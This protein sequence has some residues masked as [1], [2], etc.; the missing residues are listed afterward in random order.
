MPAAWDTSLL[1]ELR[2]GSGA[3][4]FALE[5]AGRGQPVA[6]ASTAVLES[7]YGYERVSSA[8]PDFGELLRWL[9]QQVNDPGFLHVLP[10]NAR[11][12]FAVG[13]LRAHEPAPPRASKHD[14]RAKTERRAAWVLDLQIAATC[15][16][17]GHDVATRN[18]QDFE[19]IAELLG[20]LAPGA[21]PL[22]V[23]D[24]PF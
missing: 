12:A 10:L 8:R 19:S 4:L 11:A 20:E 1:S 6:V 15:W 3:H 2:P 14:R 5:Q 18:G 16:S 7:A 22:E 13:R 9:D 17:A 21:T 24:A 23:V